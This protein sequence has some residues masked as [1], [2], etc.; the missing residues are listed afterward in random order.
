[1]GLI[2][3]LTVLGIFLYLL[4]RLFNIAM[5]T[6]DSFGYYL[7]LGL[8]VMIGSQALINF[9]VAVGLMPTKGLPLPFMS[10]GGSAFLI[11]MAA[12]GILISI[13]EDNH[14]SVACVPA[15]HIHDMRSGT[16]LNSAF[17]GN[18]RGRGFGAAPRLETEKNSAGRGLKSLHVSAWKRH[19]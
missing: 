9:A 16:G 17:S 15:R 3:V 10:Y 14:R 11:N 6:E 13:S 5:E 8:T 7:A 1:M 12:V 4:I 18:Y 2:G 19:K